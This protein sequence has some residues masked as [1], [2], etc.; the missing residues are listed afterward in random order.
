MSKRTRSNLADPKLEHCVS[1]DMSHLDDLLKDEHSRA[2]LIEKLKCDTIEQ[3][4]KLTDDPLDDDELVLFVYR[5]DV[6][7]GIVE[8]T[9]RLDHL[10][11]R[12]AVVIKRLW[13]PTNRIIQDDRLGKFYN[14]EHNFD[15]DDNIWVNT[16][17]ECLEETVFEH[18][19]PLWEDPNQYDVSDFAQ[20]G[21]LLH[22]AYVWRAVDNKDAVIEKVSEDLGT[23][24]DILDDWG[25]SAHY[26][27][28][29]HETK[30]R[31]LSRWS[32]NPRVAV[33]KL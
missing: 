11:W 28:Q 5:D 30:D 16:Y 18:C 8:H 14:D 4:L 6:G 10:P 19:I 9:L 3:I 1:T 31:L 17:V 2:Y 7:R 27:A 21:T 25:N 33:E 15:S 13:T 24:S 12:I 20:P 22:D 32:R 29:R 26:G 23:L